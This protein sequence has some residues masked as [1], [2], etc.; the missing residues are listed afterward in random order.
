LVAKKASGSFSKKYVT[1]EK[2]TCNMDR[3]LVQPYLPKEVHLTA[4][5]ECDIKTRALA[6]RE[7]G[8]ILTTDDARNLLVLNDL[9]IEVVSEGDIA[10]LRQ[11]HALEYA[12]ELLRLTLFSF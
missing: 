5:D 2:P 3:Q 1:V 12:R 10:M 4:L 9:P 8:E 6:L 7:R 11:D